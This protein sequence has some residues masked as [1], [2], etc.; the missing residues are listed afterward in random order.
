MSEEIIIDGVNVSEC[1]DFT[2]NKELDNGEV[3]EHCCFY[4]DDDCEGQKC[5]YKKL[6]RLEQKYNEVLKLAKDN[7]D[8]N[9]FV[10]QELEKE[11]GE[12]KEEIKQLHNGKTTEELYTLFGK[13]ISYWEKLEQALEEIKNNCTEMLETIK[14]EGKPNKSI[15]DTIWCK[16]IPC[17]TLYELIENTQIKIDEVLNEKQF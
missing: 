13:P 15:M 10:I 12:L 17:C 11:N 5:H 3:I 7:A 4:I 6:K 8:S 14:E 9:E 1:Y 16:N 2:Y